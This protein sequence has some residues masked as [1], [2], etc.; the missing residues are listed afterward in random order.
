VLVTNVGRHGP[1]TQLEEK[2]STMRCIS[3]ALWVRVLF[4]FLA[5]PG[6][7]AVAEETPRDPAD[8]AAAVAG[9]LAAA[10]KAKFPGQTP[11]VAVFPPSNKD[12]AV[13]AATASPAIALQGELIIRLR[14]LSMG[15]FTVLSRAQLAG[16]FKDKGI[17]PQGI[18][19]RNPQTTASTISEVD[20]DVALQA[21][22]NQ[23]HGGDLATQLNISFKLVFRDNTNTTIEKPSL[24]GTVIPPPVVIEPGG[25]ENPAS[26]RFKVEILVDG[27]PLPMK[28][29]NEPDRG[30]KVDDHGA[31]VLDANGNAQVID[32]TQAEQHLFHNVYVLTIPQ[33][34]VDQHKAF[35]IRLTNKG[36][37]FVRF[38]NTPSKDKDR[39]YAVSLLADGVSTIMRDT[40]Q[41]DAAGNPI[42]EFQVV[43]PKNA[44]KWVLSG[45]GKRAVADTSKP[46]PNMPGVFFP[47]LVGPDSNGK[48]G[49]IVDVPGFQK[50]TEFGLQFRFAAAKDSAA[51]LVGITNDIGIIRADFYPEKFDDDS[52]GGAGGLDGGG[53][54][55]GEEVPKKVF[56]IF[57][58]KQPNP[59]EVWHIFYRVQ[60]APPL[61]GNPVLVDTNP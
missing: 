57:F 61:P 31:L 17:D 9:D 41:K 50:G 29:V 36:T 52:A 42:F 47:Q 39:L 40:G 44:S 6:G 49:S 13:T 43:H 53:I 12:G 45:P 2:I 21:I 16:A 48:D 3:K 1:V 22:F 38:Q 20:L 33:S 59:V 15:N 60:G 10:I 25:A 34:F 54:K 56:P 51:A 19:A 46:V 18:D 7:I 27:N 30:L 4:A 35:R 11:R 58:E 5:I 24:P 8:L 28:R 37:P 23:A 32:A 26:G 55:A 14:S